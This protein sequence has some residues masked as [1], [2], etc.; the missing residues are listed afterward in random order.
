MRCRCWS[1]WEFPK[2]I[3]LSLGSVSVSYAFARHVIE[4][5]LDTVEEKAALELQLQDLMR[6][7]SLFAPGSV[8][9]FTSRSRERILIS[10]K[11][12]EPASFVARDSAWLDWPVDVPRDRAPA[13]PRLEREREPKARAPVRPSGCDNS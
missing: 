13:L 7:L 12:L 8:P 10:R 1:V 4:S 2:L 9:I 11:L 5:K 6:H 3:I